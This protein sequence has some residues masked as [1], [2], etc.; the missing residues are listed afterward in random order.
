MNAT[1]SKV[2]GDLASLRKEVLDLK[3]SV[4]T[5][6]GDAAK[7]LAKA[8]ELERSLKQWQTRTDQRLA[9]NEE[10]ILAIDAFRR[11]VNTELLSLR[12]AISGPN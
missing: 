4:D 9:S 6:Q 7:A 8:S 5:M 1:A 3:L 12:A 2:Q 10:A 11:S